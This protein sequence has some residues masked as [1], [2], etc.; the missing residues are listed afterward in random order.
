MMFAITENGI[1]KACGRN[2]YIEG[3]AIS[4]INEYLTE[5]PHIAKREG[6]KPIK[7]LDEPAD[8]TILVDKGDEVWEV[9][10]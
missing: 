9:V 8:N 2:G 10:I 1:T 6:Y 7:W 5:N 3:V 4:N